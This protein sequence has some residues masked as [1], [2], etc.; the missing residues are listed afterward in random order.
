MSG[1]TLMFAGITLISNGMNYL[2]KIK[3][4]SNALINI[5]TGLLYFL[6]NGLAITYGVFANE[7]PTYYYGIISGLLFGYTYLSYGLNRIFDWD[8]RNLG[9]FSLF[10]TMNS[11]LFAGL[12]FTGVASGNIFDGLNWLV[13]GGLWLTNYLI[14]NR[15]VQ[16]GNWLYYATILAGIITCWIPGLLILMDLWP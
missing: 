4:D 12:I 1:L 16:I 9:Y 11:I 6:V 7:V 15:G 8:N 3:D 14:F 13:W 2:D 5:F 10:V